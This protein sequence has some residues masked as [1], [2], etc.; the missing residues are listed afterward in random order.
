MLADFEG[1]NFVILCSPWPY[2]FQEFSSD[3]GSRPVKRIAD[4]CRLRSSQFPQ[5][6]SLFSLWDD[7]FI[8]DIDRDINIKTLHDLFRMR[9]QWRIQWD[10]ILTLRYSLRPTACFCLFHYR[11]IVR[12]VVVLIVF[13]FTLPQMDNFYTGKCCWSTLLVFRPMSILDFIIVF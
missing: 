10:H 7:C 13:P 1:W 9:V 8:F 11:L 3:M 4:V 6:L 2:C 5:V 12:T